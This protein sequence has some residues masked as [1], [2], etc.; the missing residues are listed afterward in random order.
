[1]SRPPRV[2][3]LPAAARVAVPWKNGGGVTRE[4]A[5]H[6]EGAGFEDFDWRISTA[7]VCVPGAF[8][9]FPGID[10]QL[11]VLRGQLELAFT[12][13]PIV[14]LD[15]R[16]APLAF[17]GDVPVHGVPRGGTVTDFNVMTRRRRSR[18]RVERRELTT[19]LRL[20]TPADVLLFALGP[21]VVTTS[22]GSWSLAIWDALQLAAG[23]DCEV[24]PAAAG[25]AL[26]QV[27]LASG[28]D[29]VA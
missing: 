22:A 13:R 29:G 12:D 16:S 24:M 17:P 15:S 9:Q 28:P 6:P 19:P 23:A 27:S 10:R 5:A 7:E 18:A 3:L 25:A 1:V 2:R 11:C 21:L 26:I 14:R 20:P 4:V 8:S